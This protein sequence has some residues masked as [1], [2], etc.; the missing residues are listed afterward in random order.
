MI[1]GGQMYKGKY[2]KLFTTDIK[3]DSNIPGI[4]EGPMFGLD[5]ARQIPGAKANFGWILI[6]KPLFIDKAP[7]THEGDE[8]LFFLGGQIP[9]SFSTFDAE[10]DFGIGKEQEKYTITEPTI[11]FIPAGLFHT[12]LNFRKINKPLLFGTILLTPRFTKTDINGKTFS[13]DGPGVNGAP[14]IIDI[15]KIP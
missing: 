14:K 9:D 8:Y 13:Y 15:T 10:I 7:H 11:V 4:I 5:G 1:G 3:E 2:A 6:T 12:P